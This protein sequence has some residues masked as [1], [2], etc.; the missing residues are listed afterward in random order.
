M[1]LCL[2]GVLLIGM[3]RWWRLNQVAGPVPDQPPPA[4]IPADS[5]R[6]LPPPLPAGNNPPPAENPPPAGPA[7]Q[8]TVAL[9]DQATAALQ[10]QQYDQAADLYQQAI[11]TDSHY[12]PAYFGLSEARKRSGDQ[13]GSIAALEQAVANNPHDPLPLQRLGEA[14]LM[15]DNPNQA[16]AAFEQAIDLDPNNAV[17]HAE[18]AMALLLLDQ[19]QEA[20][21]AIDTALALDPL[22][23]EARLANA[24]Y[25]AKQKQIRPA[26]HTLRELVN[27]GRA[28]VFV[29]DRARNLLNKL[30]AQAN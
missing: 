5:Q 27:E 26:T 28:P 19:D 29:R 6:E 12:L 25:L 30:N 1:L 18:Q 20:K 17:F 15:A 24:A 2:L 7:Q 4:Q 8:Q 10:R 9:A 14:W 11:E 3:L 22:S 16:L 21:E 23:P 13:A